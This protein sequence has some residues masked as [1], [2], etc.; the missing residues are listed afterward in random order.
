MYRNIKKT[1]IFIWTTLFVSWLFAAVIYTL[2]VRWN[3]AAAMVVGVVYMFIPMT[4]AIIVQKR[5]FHNLVRGPLGISFSLNRWFLVAWLLPPLVAF[6]A[7]GISLLFPGVEYSPGMEG[8][9]DRFAGQMT[10]EQMELVKTRIDALPVHP[11]LLLI[12]PGLITG[13]TVNAVAGFGEE[14]G[15]R[16]FLQRELAWLGFWKSSYIIGLV[17]GV[18]HAPIIVQGHNYP[19]HPVPGVFMMILFCLL[20]SPVIGYIRLKARSV[21]AAAVFHGTLN[22][23]AGSAVML[24]RGGND[25]L[26]GVTGLSGLLVLAGLNVLIYLRDRAGPPELK[27]LAPS[28][29]PG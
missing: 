24:S 26:T 21:I 22:A 28:V 2:G 15:W 6:A 17:W 16:G 5:V 14:L 23:T 12:I 29:G 25:I 19:M 4:V 27:E 13:I 20:A 7:L 10:P 9:L 18:W 11:V 8:L 1:G 3:T